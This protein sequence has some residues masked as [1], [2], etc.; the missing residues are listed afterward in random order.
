MD[1][2]RFRTPD[3][4][5]MYTRFPGKSRRATIPTFGLVFRRQTAHTSTR[6]RACPP[7]TAPTGLSVS[8]VFTP[9][10]C[11]AHV[12]FCSDYDGC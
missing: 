3:T 12:T 10:G 7:T 9:L 6:V 1:V 8:T 4:L 11:A 5:L 2:W